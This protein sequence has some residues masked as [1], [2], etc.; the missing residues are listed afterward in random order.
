VAENLTGIK[1]EELKDALA[2]LGA[3]VRRAGPQ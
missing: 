1:D 2:R 3:A